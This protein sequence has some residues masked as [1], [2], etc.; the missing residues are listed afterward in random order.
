MLVKQNG[1]SGENGLPY[2]EFET[3]TLCPIDTRLVDAS[4]LDPEE[5]AWLNAYHKRVYA[6]LSGHLSPRERTWLKRACSAI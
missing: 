1:V 5:R 2:F 4:L 6:S 3:L